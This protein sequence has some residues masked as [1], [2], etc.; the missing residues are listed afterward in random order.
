VTAGLRG[1][2]ALALFAAFGLACE[3]PPVVHAARSVASTEAPAAAK[4]CD[5]AVDVRDLAGPGAIDCGTAVDACDAATAATSRACILDALKGERPFYA[6]ALGPSIDSKY[7]EAFVGRRVD[8]RFETQQL[9]SDYMSYA[10]PDGP[11]WW[12]STCHPLEDLV[13]KCTPDRSWE[14]VER[15]SPACAAVV[16]GPHGGPSVKVT[17][18][19]GLWCNARADGDACQKGVR[20]ASTTRR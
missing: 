1:G 5:L 8:G 9:T 6:S 13:P 14:R 12:G 20:N 17:A 19:Y 3:S 18:A 7:V 15:L 2:G 11:T 16:D 10:Q 4:R